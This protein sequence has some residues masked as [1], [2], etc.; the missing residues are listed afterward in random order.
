MSSPKVKLT[1]LSKLFSDLKAELKPASGESR[2]SVNKCINRI[3]SRDIFAKCDNPPFDN[4]AIDGFAIKEDPRSTIKNFSLLDGLL[5]PGFKSSVVLKRNEGIKILTGAP[6][7]SGTTRIIFNENSKERDQKVYFDQTDDKEN[8]VR[9]KGEDFKKGDLLFKRGNQIRITDLAALIGSGNSSISIIKP[10]KVGLLTTGNE[11]NS[12]IEK[13]SNSF[14]FDT[15]TVPLKTLLESWGH[16]IINIGSVADDLDLLREKIFDNLERVDA[17]VTTGGA[18]TGQEDFVS[19]F[20]NREGHVVNWR[21]AIKPGRPF[22]CG[23]LG[24][25]YVF[26]LPGNPVAAFICSLIILRPSLGRIGGETNWFKPFS[27]KIKANFK[28]DKRPGRTEFL[29]ANLN[30]EDGFVSIYPF[31]GSG[32]LSSLSWSN[33]LIELPEREQNIT[34]GDLV[35]FIPYESFF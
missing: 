28:K 18:S 1:S 7:P 33:G 6:I 11:L 27:S 14:I 31:E 15:N 20:L 4:S 9:L 34:P 21:I 32:R 19:P 12:D 30:R 17:F 26:G 8:N 5:K 24:T 35:D 29:R 10:L 23:K 13:K 16:S 2:V 25:K 22:I 3:L